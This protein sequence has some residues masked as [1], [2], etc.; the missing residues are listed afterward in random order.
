MHK[1]IFPWIQGTFWV[2]SSK[3]TLRFGGWVGGAM[4]DIRGEKKQ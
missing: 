1:V 2:E 3:V 4:T